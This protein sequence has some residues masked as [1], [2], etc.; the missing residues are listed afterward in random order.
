MAS[1]PSQKVGPLI[2]AL[3]SVSILRGWILTQDGRFCSRTRWR[4]RYGIAVPKSARAV[5]S[6]WHGGLILGGIGRQSLYY[7]PCLYP[8]TGHLGALKATV[9]EVDQAHC[10]SDRD[11]SQEPLL[12]MS[13]RIVVTSIFTTYLFCF[14][15]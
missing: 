1:A 15:T 3:P 10:L 11:Q 9:E 5:S 7:G 14:R 2:Q 13:S 12:D 8:L 4:Q 6:Y